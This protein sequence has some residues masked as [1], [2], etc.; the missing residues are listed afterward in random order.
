MSDAPVTP[1]QVRAARQLRGWSQS[2]L[3]GHLGVSTST[4]WAFESGKRRPSALNLDL[5]RAVLESAGAIFVEEYG[6]GPG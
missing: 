1:G 6:E 4:V 5:V 3:A 2:D